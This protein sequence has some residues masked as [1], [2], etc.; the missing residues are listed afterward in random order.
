MLD[1]K[2]TLLPGDP[3][4]PVLHPFLLTGTPRL[5]VDV[6]VTT[7]VVCHYYFVNFVFPSLKLTV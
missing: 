3:E 6:N 5:T 1:L 2:R 4:N 7:P